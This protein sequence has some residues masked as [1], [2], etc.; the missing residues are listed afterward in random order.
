[1]SYLFFGVIC[2]V[3]GAILGFLA[4]LSEL[5]KMIDESR[6]KNDV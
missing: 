5:R 4:A 1:M 2:F 6:G 3:L